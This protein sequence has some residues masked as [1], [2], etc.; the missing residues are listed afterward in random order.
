M[1]AS[2]TYQTVT[3]ESA[4]RGDYSEHGWVLPGMWKYALQDE[5]GYHENVLDEAKRGEFDLTGLGEI[6]SFAQSL[7]VCTGEGADWFYSVDDDMDY[8]TGERTQYCLHLEG[9][10]PATETR[11]LRLIQN[12]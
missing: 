1:K 4:E 12:Y 5:D 6:V 7:G 8:E 11:I 10:T 9:V 2:F 3:Q